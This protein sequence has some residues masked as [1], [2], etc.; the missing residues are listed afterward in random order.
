MHEE[1]YGMDYK[2]WEYRDDHAEVRRS[3][4]LVIS[5]IATIGEPSSGCGGLA[6]GLWTLG[7][8]GGRGL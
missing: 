5:F 7:G 8:G 2:H 4:R 6:A 1:D 3:R